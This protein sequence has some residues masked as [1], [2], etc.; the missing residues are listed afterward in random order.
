[1]SSDCVL[2]KISQF[3]QDIYKDSM[4]CILSLKNRKELI[5][6]EDQIKELSDAYQNVSKEEE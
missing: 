4:D 5:Q 2:E 1:M 6:I 3:I